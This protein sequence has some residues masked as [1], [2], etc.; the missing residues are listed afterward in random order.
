MNNQD[1]INFFCLKKVIDNY[2]PLSETEWHDL[3]NTIKVKSLKKNE[4]LVKQGINCYSLYYILSGSVRIFFRTESGKEVSTKFAFEEQFATALA[5]FLTQTPSNENIVTLEDSSFFMLNHHTFQELLNKY[6][7]CEKLAREL[8][9]N[10]YIQK[11][12][13]EQLL[14]E[15]PRERYK[16]FSESGKQLLQRIEQKHIASYLGMTP[17]TLCRIK[18][19]VLVS[20]A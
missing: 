3:Q 9:E 20:G 15:N 19:K 6:P 12:Y 2:F 4:Y 17:E 1:T 13:R 16:K 18:R 11:A 5:S 8:T 10:H 7:A 14:L